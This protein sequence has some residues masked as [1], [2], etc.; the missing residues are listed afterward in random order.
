MSKLN[1]E[2]NKDKCT[3][4]GLC[5]KICRLG[6]IQISQDGYPEVCD[7]SSCI[8]CQ[9]CFAS[10]PVGAI[11]IFGK[12]SELSVNKELF[13]SP[14]NML[15]LIKTRYSCRNYKDENVSVD[16]INKLKEMLAYVPTGCNNHGLH[17][18]IVEDKAFMED[19]RE[20]ALGM[21]KGY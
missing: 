20:Q 8:K 15:N 3:K 9:H 19:F 17:F 1:F 16:K 14:D 10:C 7:E 18:A 11:S 12:R 13:V 6:V 4:C 2:L 21:L 5:T